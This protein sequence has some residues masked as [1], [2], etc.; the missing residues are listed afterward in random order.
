[1]HGVFAIASLA[2][3]FIAFLIFS[4]G[5]PTAMARILQP[6]ADIPPVSG[7]LYDVFVG[8]QTE[9]GDCDLLRGEDID[10]R[11]VVTK[12]EVDP[13]GSPDSLRLDIS[14]VDAD[15]HVKRLNYGLPDVRDGNTT[16]KLSGL[17]HSFSYR[18][19]GGGTWSK[20]YRVTML[21]RPRIVGLQTALHYPKYMR[22]TGTEIG[23]ARFARRDGTD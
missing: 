2:A 15:G 1:M 10:F 6:F 4:N 3:L 20:E 16:L 9:P 12:G 17:Q 13:P 5:L 22:S 7:V 18:V 14:T 19:R 23:V 8:D 11:V 21:D